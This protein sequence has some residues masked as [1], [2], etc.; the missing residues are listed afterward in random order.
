MIASPQSPVLPAGKRGHL[1][2]KRCR[3]LGIL[4]NL[5]D[6]ALPVPRH[7]AAHIPKMA[8]ADHS[9]VSHRF[10]PAIFTNS[11]IAVKEPDYRYLFRVKGTNLAT[12]TAGAS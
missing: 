3:V 1:I 2:G 11:E 10:T 12:E 7:E 9:I 4:L 8:L 5:G 6:D